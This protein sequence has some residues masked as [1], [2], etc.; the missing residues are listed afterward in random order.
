M[1]RFANPRSRHPFHMH[2]MIRGQPGFAEETLARLRDLDG[3]AFL[4]APRRILVTGCGTSFHAALLG[5][6]LLQEALGTRTI[7]H[8]VHA[9]DLLHGTDVPRDAV[10][11]GVSHSGATSTTNQAL[12]LARRSGADTRA[13]CG[14]PGS[15][16]GEVAEEVLVTG[17]VHDHS[18]ANTMSYTT[19][20]TAFARLAET[21]AQEPRE[22]FPGG[23]EAVPRLIRRALGTEPAIRRLAKRVAARDRVTFLGGGLDEVTALEAALKI[24][25]TCSF[26]A[27]GYHVEQFLHGPF[28]SLD[29][30]EALV[31]LRSRQD[32]DRE[33]EILRGVARTGASVTV[34]G[35]ARGAHIRLPP[36]DR[37]LRPIVSVIPLQYLAYYVALERKKDPD[38]MRSEDPRYRRGLEPLFA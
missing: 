32:D 11:L 12:G 30:R 17:S 18:W 5:A 19:Q 1:V 4:G 24:R 33:T 15:P 22:L 13:L 25:E 38:V 35:E 6:R 37:L 16:M 28:L 29:R 14:L 8:A 3:R 27:S 36:A 9:Y 34:V 2:D 10:V 31:A 21:L 23:V 7:V 26:P 20:L